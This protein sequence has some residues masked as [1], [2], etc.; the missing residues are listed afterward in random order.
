MQASITVEWAVRDIFVGIVIRSKMRS[1]LKLIQC[2]VGLKNS[3]IPNERPQ[4]HICNL[5]ILSFPL[6]WK[7]YCNQFTINYNKPACDIASINFYLVP[8]ESINAQNILSQK[9]SRIQRCCS[10]CTFTHPKH[11]HERQLIV[12]RIGDV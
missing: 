10:N 7:S 1:S 11:G 12:L 4:A 3:Y 8:I 5:I 6:P 2:F 9:C